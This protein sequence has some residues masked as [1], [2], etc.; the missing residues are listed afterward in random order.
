MRNLNI[1]QL[2]KSLDCLCQFLDDVY[3]VNNGGCCLIAY[4]IAS[5]L[6]KL[7]VKYSLVI[8]NDSRKC[9]SGITRE[10]TS[11]SKATNPVNSITGKNT[12][13]HYALRIYRG[14]YINRG[15]VSPCDLEYRIRGIY[16]ENIKWIYDTG[17]WNKEYNTK[18]S[19]SIKRIIDSF[20]EQYQ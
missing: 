13:W 4:L 19:K 12:C 20:F 11:M 2:R 6:D 14:G 3:R 10:V 8:Y 9:I 5:N 7:G 17:C 16:S 1:K 15:C 18:N